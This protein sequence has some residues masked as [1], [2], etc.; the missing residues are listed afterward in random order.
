MVLRFTSSLSR[1]GLRLSLGLAG[2]L[3]SAGLVLATTLSLFVARSTDTAVRVEWEVAT[4]TDLTAFSLSR[5]QAADPGFLPLTTLAPTGQRHYTYADTSLAPGPLGPVMYRL[6]LH[7][8]GPDQTYTTMVP[9]T[10]GLV[11]RSWGTVKAMFR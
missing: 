5:K 2:L 4:E 7:S 1:L 10:M 6:T 8:A 9:G 3:G 11:A